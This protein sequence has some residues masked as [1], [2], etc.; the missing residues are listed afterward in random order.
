MHYVVAC[1]H[2]HCNKSL[3]SLQSQSSSSAGYI[4]TNTEAFATRADYDVPEIPSHYNSGTLP[5]CLQAMEHSRILPASLAF[6][7]SGG[8]HLHG[9]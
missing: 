4:G 7:M 9:V 3:T 6:C 1:C 5:V 2:V 8:L